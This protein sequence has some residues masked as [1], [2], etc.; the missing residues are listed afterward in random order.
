MIPIDWRDELTIRAA[1]SP[2]IRLR[3]DWLPSE[4]AIAGQ[5]GVAGH[6]DRRAA[7][8]KI[9]N[10]DANLVH[11]SL[12]WFGE[13]FGIAGGFDVELL[14]RIPA[15]AGLGGA[16]S[17]AAAALR[18]A[19]TLFGIAPSDPAV[20]AIAAELGSD[21]PFFLGE[22]SVPVP[23]ARALGRGERLEPLRSAVPLHVVVVFPDESL[24]TGS[25]YAQ[26]QVPER[27]RTAAALIDA[28]SR[29][30][31]AEVV[32]AMHNR[33]AAP[34]Q[35]I[36]PRVNEILTELSQSGL[37]GGLMTGSGSACFAIAG[38]GAQ[39]ETTAKGLSRKLTPGAIVVAT[40]SVVVPPEIEIG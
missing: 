34:A 6:P 17:D 22:G 27:P 33:L 11:R 19:A 38:S 12:K 16:S 7:L 5:L 25:V 31:V 32:A 10:D 15:G 30:S 39:A 36:S 9:P 40:Q 21:V 37:M 29:G 18:S 23:A 1:D 28:L 13:R 35:K 20:R 26:S 2:G 4:A 24:S 14:K 3:T 8:L